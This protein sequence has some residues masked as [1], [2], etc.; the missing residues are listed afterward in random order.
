MPFL[1]ALARGLSTL[2]VNGANNGGG[3]NGGGNNPPPPRP[4]TSR[5]QFTHVPGNSARGIEDRW[6]LPSVSP[7]VSS[8]AFIGWDIISTPNIASVAQSTMA[9]V[10]AIATRRPTPAELTLLDGVSFLS[11]EFDRSAR[12][13]SEGVRW[14]AQS[15]GTGRRC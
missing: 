2:M 14:R 5:T 12:A 9:G 7:V 10:L 1:L 3:G 4:A 15:A 6:E 8:L 13:G 11:H